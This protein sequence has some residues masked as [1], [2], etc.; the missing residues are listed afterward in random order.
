MEWAARSSRVT[1][2]EGRSG[3]CLPCFVTFRLDKA[4]GRCNGSPGRAG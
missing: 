2:H 3:P 1:T 4:R